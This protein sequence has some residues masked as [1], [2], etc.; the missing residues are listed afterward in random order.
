MIETAAAR[1][2]VEQLLHV[3]E[4]LGRLLASGWRQAGAEAA[5]L[6]HDAATLAEAGLI[7]VAARLSAVAEAGSVSEALPAIAVAASAC[8]LL[9][10]RLLA[11]PLPD[12]WI[13][14]D[15]LRA[16][17]R[18]GPDTLLPVARLLLEGR[19]VWL[20]AW[21]KGTQ[22]TH[23]QWLLIEAPLPASTEPVAEPASTPGLFVRLRQRVG[24]AL[25]VTAAS[26]APWLSR[27]L[28]GR[29]VWQ[30]RYPVGAD[31]QV[32]LCALEDPA[33]QSELDQRDRHRHLREIL[34]G[35][36]PPTT[37]YLAA[38]SGIRLMEIRRADAATYTWLDPS[39]AEA[40]AAVPTEKA[41]AVVWTERAAMMPVALVTPA[42]W[43]SP[44]RLTH[45][46]PG[47]PT[48]VLSIPS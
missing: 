41:W 6:R 4:R 45:L 7:E 37:T 15:P 27:Q 25:G 2:L 17:S 36:A 24:R 12:G 40:F 38:T 42:G 20:C 11:S 28:R 23:T 19:E 29:L 31:S 1:E 35:R 43:G 16:R 47:S 9:R 14:L 48:D 8:R 33:W 21:V 26:G 22:W 39:A 34:A 46:L 18:T 44:A 32:T 13:P 10:I 5:D 3:E 30:A